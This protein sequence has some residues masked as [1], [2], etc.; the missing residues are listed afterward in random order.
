MGDNSSSSVYYKV[1]IIQ[2]EETD[3]EKR[4]PINTARHL[5]LD[6]TYEQC[7]ASPSRWNL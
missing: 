1:L 3:G 7:S 5:F 6:G 2:P 4:E